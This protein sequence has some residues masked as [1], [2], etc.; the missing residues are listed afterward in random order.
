MTNAENITNG[1]AQLKEPRGSNEY[2]RFP[3][4]GNAGEAVDTSLIISSS[5]GPLI[6]REW[7]MIPI[8]ARQCVRDF[9]A[10]SRRG[11]GSFRRAPLSLLD[12]SHRRRK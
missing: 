11:V 1:L 5:R 3:N 12:R 6:S 4:L 7:Q 10:R 8:M 2:W 9:S